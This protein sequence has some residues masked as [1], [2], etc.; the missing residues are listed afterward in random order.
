MTTT[1]C[2]Y[3]HASCQQKEK[4][5]VSGCDSGTLSPPIN[6]SF[7]PCMPHYEPYTPSQKYTHF[8]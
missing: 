6:A 5:R 1:F 3:S 2:V 8:G 4:K 7:S